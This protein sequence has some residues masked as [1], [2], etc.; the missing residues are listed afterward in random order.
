MKRWYIKKISKQSAISIVSTIEKL[1]TSS[2][3]FLLLMVPFV[4]YLQLTDSDLLY[5]LFFVIC[6]PMM[7]LILVFISNPYVN[8]LNYV[9][10][11]DVDL[12]KYVNILRLLP[13]ESKNK[14]FKREYSQASLLAEGRYQY[15]K[16]NF[17]QSLRFLNQVDFSLISKKNKNI[18]MDQLKYYTFLN[19][20]YLTKV[21]ESGLIPSF[22]NE[23]LYVQLR[24]ILNVV[25]GE[26]TDYFSIWNPEWKL[27]KIMKNYYSALNHLNQNQPEEAKT[28]FQE[29]V[30]ENPDLFYVKE[31]K[32]YLEEL[33]S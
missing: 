24:A 25:N 9:L 18:Y 33:E 7:W 17:E 26:K 2:L 10:Q 30:N 19:E 13:R 8:V 6:V 4:F 23:K 28:C 32:K 16:G 11:E 22:I 15:L 29:I 21:S 27:E 31:A 20:L 3:I 5:V 14:K 1:F 12:D